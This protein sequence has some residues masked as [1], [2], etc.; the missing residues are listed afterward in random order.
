M[1]TIM[2]KSGRYGGL[3]LHKQPEWRMNT[4]LLLVHNRF[5]EKDFAKSHSFTTFAYLLHYSYALE[6][7]L[8]TGLNKRRGMK[9]DT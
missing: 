3:C 7:C 4:I 9:V 8:S 5:I 6:R 2:L 1:L